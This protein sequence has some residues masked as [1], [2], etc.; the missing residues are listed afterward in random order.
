[1]WVTHAKKFLE[2]T[3]NPKPTPLKPSKI[4]VVICSSCQNTLAIYKSEINLVNT[5][6]KREGKP[7]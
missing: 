3:K 2:R 1:M 5:G 7:T 6:R 4:I